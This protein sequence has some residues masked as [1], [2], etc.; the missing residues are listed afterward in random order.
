MVPEI[1]TRPTRAEP[2]EVLELKRIKTVQPELAPAVDLQIALFDLQRRVQA[3]VP[4]PSIEVAPEWLK[5][6]HE[7]ARPLLRF[8]D[9]PLDWTDFRLVFRQTADVLRRFEALEAPEYHA[10]QAM[11]R[12]GHALEP[13]VVRWFNEAAAP[14]RVKTLDVPLPPGISTPSLDQ[15]LTL[16]MRPFLERCAEMVQ[17]RVD[18]STWSHPNCPLCGGEPEFGVHTSAGDRLLICG[19]CTAR[20]GFDRHTCPFCR[21][22]DRELLHSFTSRDALY[23]VDACDVCRRYIKS[24][25]ARRGGRPVMLA[26]DSVATLT[27]DAAAMQRGYRG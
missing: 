3:R 19:R 18:L 13:H 25:D 10:I 6:Q 17:Q 11:S 8:E 15:V 12:D 20:W 9:I 22:A 27:L 23:R 16:A 14:E 2:R 26:A 7:A 24:Y 4:M 21:N 5:R 1:R